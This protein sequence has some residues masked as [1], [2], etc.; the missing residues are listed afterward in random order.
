MDCVIFRL[1][2]YISRLSIL[3]SCASVPRIT[4]QAV[5]RLPPALVLAISHPRFQCPLV[6]AAWQPCAGKRLQHSDRVA[7]SSCSCTHSSSGYSSYLLHTEAS[8]KT[9]DKRYRVPEVDQ[10][11]LQ[12]LWLDDKARSWTHYFSTHHL[13]VSERL[14]RYHVNSC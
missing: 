11:S 10:R 5:R 12:T 8:R 4:S 14:L 13:R 9:P 2:S 1:F 3:Q 7:S 6:A